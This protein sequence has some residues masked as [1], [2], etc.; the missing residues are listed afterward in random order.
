MWNKS[1][2]HDE[3]GAG[4]RIHLAYSGSATGYIYPMVI[5]VSRLSDTE[6]PNDNFLVV[7]VKK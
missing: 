4:I 2:S 5:I 6:I 7:P 1:D 3:I